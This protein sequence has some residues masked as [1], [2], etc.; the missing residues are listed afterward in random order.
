MLLF[1]HEYFVGHRQ[2]TFPAGGMPAATS[3]ASFLLN[4]APAF[5]LPARRQFPDRFHILI[6][7]YWENFVILK[8]FQC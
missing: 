6:S 4:P 7:F 1:L 5:F 2:R 3:G 8:N